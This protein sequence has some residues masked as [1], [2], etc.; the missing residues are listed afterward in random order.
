M[1]TRSFDDLAQRAAAKWTPAV[2][3][4]AAKF[5]AELDGEM[6][7]Q[8]ELGRQIAAA[9]LSARLTQT[10]LAARAFVQ[11][12]EIS[13]IERGLGNPTRDTLLRLAAAMGVRLAL[14]PDERASRT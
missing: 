11:Q 2:K 3:E 1:A 7:A 4:F 14:V 8:A 12:A 10:E 6:T 5:N 13:R 9:R